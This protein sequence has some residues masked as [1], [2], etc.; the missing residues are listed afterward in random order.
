MNIE[1]MVQCIYGKVETLLSIAS[2]RQALY[3]NRRKLKKPVMFHW[4]LFIRYHFEIAGYIPQAITCVRIN[5]SY[6]FCYNE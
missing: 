1:D 4:F 5:H 6:V 3:S 2:N